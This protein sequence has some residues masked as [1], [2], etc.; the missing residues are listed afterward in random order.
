MGHTRKRSSGNSIFRVVIVALSFLM[1][2]GWLLGQILLWNR[3]SGYIL[4]LTYL[5]AA[6]AVLHIHSRQRNAAYKLP[7]I[8][9]IM[10]VPILGLS[11]YLIAQGSVSHRSIR[12]RMEK[13]ERI[14]SAHLP[15]NGQNLEKLEDR[16]PAAAN[17]SRYLRHHGGSPLYS[18]T[19]T[20]Y[21]GETLDALEDLKR[22]LNGAES[23]IFMEYFILQEG[24]AFGQLREILERKAAQGVEVRLMYDD[25]GSIGTSSWRYAA[26]LCKCGIQCRAFN[27][28]VP[29]LSLF[30]NNRDHRK[31]T[32][33]DGKIGYTGGYN[34]ADEYF[35]YTSPYGHWKDTGV[36][37][38]GPAVR[39]LTAQFLQMW[40]VNLRTE[41][42]VA[43]Y[44]QPQECVRAPGFVQPFG[45]D[46]L[47]S[48]RVTE[49][50]LLTLIGAAKKRIWFMTPYLMITDQLSRGLELAA[51]RGVDVRILVP[52][53]P[54]KR[55]VRTLNT[56]YFPGLLECGVRIFTYDPGFCHGKVCVCDGETACIGTSNLD[57]R[58]L[59]LHFENN[60]MLYRCEAVS[61]AEADLE[62]LFESCTEIQ[63]TQ[64][65]ALKRLWQSVLRLF[66]PLL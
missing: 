15:E 47:K 35:H 42:E 58:S 6:A 29:V 19:H 60:V 38:E 31:I 62:A 65:A 13:M 4:F 17:L 16:D 66:A 64:P 1:Q 22:D 14:T 21:Y 12:R 8:M 2:I 18:G 57:Y 3:Y 9:L 53:I 37:L 34:L 24:E 63:M 52:G 20:R 33:I 49:N 43:H 23:F 59:Y 48:E 27:P 28:A 44:L 11:L 30:L 40:N 54:D 51:K 46:P 36:R 39:S 7:W 45:D 32:V 50:V 25:L 61:Q 55:I 41:E 26:Q 5:I 10:A 56:S